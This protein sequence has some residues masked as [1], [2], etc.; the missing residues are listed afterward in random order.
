METIRVSLDKEL[1]STGFEH[2]RKHEHDEEG[3]ILRFTNTWLDGPFDNS[4]ANTSGK[5]TEILETNT[6]AGR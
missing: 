6:E 5:F 2:P 4:P 3:P 1:G